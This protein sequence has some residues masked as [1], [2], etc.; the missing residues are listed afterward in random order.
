MRRNLVH[1][2]L[3]ILFGLNAHCAFAGDPTFVFDR[4]SSD[5]SAYPSK[6]E[7]HDA[8]G[9]SV[10]WWNIREGGAWSRTLPGNPLEHNLI[11]L[12]RSKFAPEVIMLGEFVAGSFERETDQI[13]K[14]E[15]PYQLYV[16][17]GF[18]RPDLGIQIFSKYP[19]GQRTELLDWSPLNA[20][21]QKRAAFKQKWREHLNT[22]ADRL[23]ERSFTDLTLQKSGRLFHLVPVHLLNPWM[24]LAGQIGQTTAGLVMVFGNDNPHY[25]QVERL[26][27][28]KMK[29]LLETAKREHSSVLL[30]GD[31]NLPDVIYGLVPRGYSLMSLFLNSVESL[32]RGQFTFP[33][34]SSDVKGLKRMTIDHAWTAADTGVVAHARIPFTGS[35]HYPISVILRAK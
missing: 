7:N 24:P 2:I 31:F 13:L 35:D 28:E 33:A 5:S 22:A 18:H 10:F 16:P 21:S 9:L 15:Y 26:V 34:M 30:M 4:V 19:L 11:E 32:G 14:H 12:A 17:Y 27:L 3:A 20:S 8:T 1:S 6:L 23:Y 29:P 25:R